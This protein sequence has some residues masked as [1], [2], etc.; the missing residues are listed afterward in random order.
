MKFTLNPKGIG[1]VNQALDE[2]WGDVVASLELEMEAV[3]RDP[4][5]FADQ[6]F[7]DQDIVDTE[8]FVNSQVVTVENRV[9]KF[10]WNPTS[11]ETGYK[12]AIAL[13]SGFRAYGRGKYIPGRKWPEK[14]VDR[15]DVPEKLKAAMKE[16]G[17]K[18]KVKIKR[19]V[20]S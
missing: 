10:A 6:G 18:A 13:Y 3:I 14:A 1:K 17:I 7:T 8:R 2:A 11:P 15:V 5:A 16:R 20:Y 4:S 12:Y 9:A 19:K